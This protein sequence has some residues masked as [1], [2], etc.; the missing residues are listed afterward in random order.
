MQRELWQYFPLN[1]ERWPMVK[2]DDGRSLPI[3][4]VTT[5]F[6]EIH[7]VM[8]PT[9]ENHVEVHHGHNTVPILDAWS[10]YR[11]HY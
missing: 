8:N 4:E 6:C 7:P 1:V 3:E 9:S 11:S 2:E 5:P 10:Q